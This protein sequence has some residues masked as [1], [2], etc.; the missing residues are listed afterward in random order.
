MDSEAV[1]E[2]SVEEEIWAE[3]EVVLVSMVVAL[4]TMEVVSMAVI[5]ISEAFE[6]AETVECPEEACYLIGVY[7]NTSFQ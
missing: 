2:V 1:E 6:V 7:I 4:V 3:E 5:P